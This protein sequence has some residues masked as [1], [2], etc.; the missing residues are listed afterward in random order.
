MRYVTSHAWLVYISAY[1]VKVGITT[2]HT[3]NTKIIILLKECHS[4]LYSS[5]GD[6]R[7]VAA[8]EFSNSFFYQRHPKLF[9]LSLKLYMLNL[10]Q[11]KLI[12]I[13]Y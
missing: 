1:S 6:Q 5:P 10:S 12:H 2:L 9:P 13:Q 11:T 7:L 4:T 8:V 3:L